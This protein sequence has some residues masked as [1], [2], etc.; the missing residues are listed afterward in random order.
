MNAA[1][2]AAL[3]PLVGNCFV[4]AFKFDE[5][6]REYLNFESNCIQN[7]QYTTKYQTNFHAS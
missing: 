1:I 5:N 3:K 6:I 7:T 2:V 4:N